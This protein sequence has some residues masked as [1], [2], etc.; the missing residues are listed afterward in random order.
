M[1]QSHPA[2]RILLTRYSLYGDRAD[3]D[4]QGRM[5]IPEELR[6]KA[7]LVGEVKVSGEGNFIRVTSLKKLRERAQADELTPQMLDSLGLQDL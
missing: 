7:E 3:M 5:Q 4:P 2:R 6:T 1:P